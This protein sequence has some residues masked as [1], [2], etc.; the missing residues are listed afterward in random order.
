MSTSRIIDRCG[1]CGYHVLNSILWLGYMQPA[2]TMPSMFHPAKEETHY[3]LE[4]LECASCSLVQLSCIVDPKV[5]FHPAYPYSTGNTKALRENFAELATTVRGLVNLTGDDLV[6]DIGSNDGT[7]LS[8]FGMVNVLGYEPTDQALVAR[9]R[10]V[11]TRQ[12][13]FTAHEARFREGQAKIVTA[14]N[15]LAHVEDVHD[16]LDGVAKL[17]TDDGIFVTENHYLGSLVNELQWDTIYHEHL[18]YYS[19]NS[20]RSL[21]EKHGLHVFRADMIASHGGS[22]RVF[23]SKRESVDIQG[24]RQTPQPWTEH[25]GLHTFAERVVESKRSILE[26]IAGAPGRVVA[27]GAAA[28]GA[29]LLNYCGLDADAIDYVIEVSNS[30]KLGHYMPGTRIPVVDEALLFEQQPENLLLLAWPLAHHLVP[31]LAEK[32]Y[33]GNVIVPLGPT[34]GRWDIRTFMHPETHL[35]LVS[36]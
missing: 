3:P 24:V 7:L 36:L 26:M 21:L 8:N 12:A 13:F 15:V 25:R 20:L 28:R 23:A 30:D 29:T 22:L 16:T 31:K 19:A 17:L 27:M 14:C 33:R 6:V 9:E 10:L 4:L 32:G 1:A 11:P 18:R 35:P 34:A 2:C 5:I